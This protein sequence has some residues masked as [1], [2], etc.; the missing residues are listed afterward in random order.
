MSGCAKFS[1]FFTRVNWLQDE[2][3]RAMVEMF[4]TT[5]TAPCQHLGLECSLPKFHKFLDHV[6]VIGLMDGESSV[7]DTDAWES[8]LSDNIEIRNDG[9]YLNRK[10]RWRRASLNR[11]D[12]KSKRCYRVYFGHWRQSIGLGICYLLPD[13]C[14]S[15]ASAA[16]F[17][18]RFPSFLV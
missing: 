8:D 15:G 11:N 4:C 12:V 7:R 16:H 3:T 2:T 17:L 5:A 10:L 6:P 13:S 1:F 18:V 9:R 14:A